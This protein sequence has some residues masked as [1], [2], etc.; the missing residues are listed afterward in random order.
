MTTTAAS[1]KD[2]MKEDE[3]VRTRRVRDIGRP[4]GLFRACMDAIRV[5]HETGQ[6]LRAAALL[7]GVMTDRRCYAELLGQFYLCTAALER[8]LQEQKRSRKLGACVSEGDSSSILVKISSLGYSFTKDYEADLSA[9]LGERWED[10][11][12]EISVPTTGTYVNLIE[13][14]ARS[15]DDPTLVAAAFILW[16]PLVIGGGAA[17]RPKVKRRF[18]EECIH[19]FDSVTGPRREER[20]KRFVD[21]YDGLVGLS[22][23]EETKTFERIVN[24]SSK[25]MTLNNRLMMECRQ[26]PWWSK[27]VMAGMA[28]AV[29]FGVGVFLA[30]D[31]TKK[32]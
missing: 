27:Y 28:T 6:K 16:G 18:G 9:L 11:I 8:A 3:D 19:V 7:A 4:G 13:E 26:R 30:A 25:F 31:G 10:I 22:E 17:L 15:G 21:C 20:K 24:L 32:K 29:A 23:I 1:N 14:A 2:S 12:K 5:P